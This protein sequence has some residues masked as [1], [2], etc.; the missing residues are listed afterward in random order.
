MYNTDDNYDTINEQLIAQ[1][2][3]PNNKV[4]SCEMARI[5]A[6]YNLPVLYNKDLN[7]SSLCRGTLKL[8]DTKQQRVITR[9]SHLFMWIFFL[10][11]YE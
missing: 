8:N 7:E 3:L 11:V 10:N 5:I 6:P 1:H 2:Q 9:T 4:R